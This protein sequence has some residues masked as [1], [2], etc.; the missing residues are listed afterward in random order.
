VTPC[1]SQWFLNLFLHEASSGNDSIILIR[2]MTL[3]LPLI[4]SYIIITSNAPTSH[5]NV[6]LTGTG[7][8]FDGITSSLQSTND[9]NVYPNPFSGITNLSF[10]ISSKMVVKLQ[11]FDMDGKEI[12]KLVSDNLSAGKYVYKWD[13][14]ALEVG[15]YT[16]RLQ[17]GNKLLTRKLIVIK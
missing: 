12:V 3:F 7:Y 6:T 14:S 13:A 2:F 16:C 4:Y 8:G 11:V 5:D 9:L 10:G 15:L 17:S 1:A